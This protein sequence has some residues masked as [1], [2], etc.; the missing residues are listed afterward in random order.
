[1]IRLIEA[2]NFRS[3]RYVRQRLTD[4]QI[5]IGPNASG[6]STFLNT[7]GFLRDLLTKGLD[8]V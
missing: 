7:V 8:A 2:L 1:M 6:K 5:L 3:L 4:F